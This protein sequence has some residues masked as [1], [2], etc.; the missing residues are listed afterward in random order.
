[1]P[2]DADSEPFQ[3]V[4]TPLLE[5]DSEPRTRAKDPERP[6][7]SSDSAVKV[8]NLNEIVAQSFEDGLVGDRAAMGAVSVMS[9][10]DDH[11]APRTKAPVW[12]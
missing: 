11:A 5:V 10:E 9:G 4:T 12:V 2:M 1:M 6:P 3:L 7:P 8:I